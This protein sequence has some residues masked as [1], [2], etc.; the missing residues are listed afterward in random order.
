[1]SQ[2]SI[3]TFFKPLSEKRKSE[4]PI[5]P[6]AKIS[7]IEKVPDKEKAPVSADEKAKRETLEG[8]FSG[9]KAMDYSWIEAL[10]P[11][12][13]KDKFNSLSKF[14]AAKRKE[15]TVYPKE[16]DVFNWAKM[17][18]NKT[19]VVIL[20]QDPY[21]GPNQAHGLSFSVLR[22]TP[23]PPSLKNMFKELNQDENVQFNTP[24]HG[25]L[26]AWADQGVLL[27]NACLTVTS[28]KAN[29]HKDKGLLITFI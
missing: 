8:L 20:G 26:T 10:L 2:R 24:N 22:P 4:G 14:V 1:M 19:K 23:P 16:A 18:I 15:G 17:N 6:D 11:K 12:M 3:N 21:H 25:D 5:G 7:R 27:L 13:E 29:S 9:I 28:S